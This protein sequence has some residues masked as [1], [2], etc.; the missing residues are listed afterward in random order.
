MRIHNL[1]FGLATNSSS[2]H[3][4]IFAKGAR[5]KDADGSFGWDY[6]TA[7][8]KQAKRLYAALVL[9]SN[10]RL[11][12]DATA[13]VVK[14]W[15]DAEPGGDDYIDHQSVYVL[16]QDW[17]G[18]CADREFFDD[19]LAFMMREDV[20]V[21]GGN[22]NTDAAHPLDN[23]SAFVLPLDR[24]G[25]GTW[26]A[27]KDQAGYWTCFSRETGAK[28]R[29][30]F[31]DL[32]AAPTKASVPELVDI[33]ITD[34]CNFGCD[35][36]YQGSTPEGKHA[37]RGWIDSLAYALGKMRVFEVAIGG[38]EPT[39][40]PQFADI[41]HA[42]RHAGVVPNFTT[43]SLAWL[44]K[45]KEWVPI[46]SSAG[47]FAYSVGAASD[48]RR[49]AI[50]LDD[51]GISPARASVQYVMGSTPLDELASIIKAAGKDHLRVT[52]LGYKTNGRGAQFR[53]HDYSGWLP[54]VQKARDKHWTAIGIDTALAADFGP[55]LKK[56]GV[57]SLYYTTQEGKFSAYIDA[58]EKKIGPSSYCDPMLMRP[59][60]TERYSSDMERAIKSTFA[61]F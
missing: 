47:A 2:T 54:V 10:L 17:E 3:S 9:K 59:L 53:P 45:P 14:A 41:L 26:V 25:G 37:D 30:S 8:S 6:F 22:D 13:A 55:Q 39:L 57:D 44:R 61:T 19:F 51:N 1:R 50:L 12:D 15:A 29:F 48:V 58:V 40:H 42:F 43:K 34:H 28:I 46:L 20:V 4:L 36:C 7:A 24:D 32:A 31:D 16:P 33:K 38:G 27:R 60:S 23:G 21:L 11:P 18:R 49:L 35:F 5:D 56:A 52:L